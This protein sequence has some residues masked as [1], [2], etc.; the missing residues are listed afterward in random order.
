[1][2][3][4][5]RPDV[6]LVTV[7]GEHLLVAAGRARGKVPAVKGINRPGAYFW[8]RLERGLEEGEIVAQAAADYDCPEATAR[9]AL[10]RVLAVLEQ[11]GYL[12]MEGET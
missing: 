10:D 12:L 6:V 4:R 7:C 1:M 5:L 9:E 8:E 3:H 2:I 11:E